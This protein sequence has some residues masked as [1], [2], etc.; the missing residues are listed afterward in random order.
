MPMNNETIRPDYVENYLT[1]IN[2][3]MKNHRDTSHLLVHDDTVN[4]NIDELPH[5][6]AADMLAKNVNPVELAMLKPANLTRSV[7]RTVF[8][9]P[10]LKSCIA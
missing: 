1:L 7:V 8:T 6:V 9:S 10:L 5:A 2:W 4:R 3:M